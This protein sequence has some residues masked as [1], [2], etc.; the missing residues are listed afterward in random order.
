MASSDRSGLFHHDKPSKGMDTELK[1]EVVSGINRFMEVA[2]TPYTKDMK[3]DVKH[4]DF[5]DSDSE[6]VKWKDIKGSPCLAI[7]LADIYL[8]PGM[9]K[10]DQY[11]FDIFKKIF[12]SDEK[13]A[14][15]I[16]INLDK[17][18]PEYHLM[19]QSNKLDFTTFAEKLATKMIDLVGKKITEIESDNQSSPKPKQAAI[20]ILTE[21]NTSLKNMIKNM[22]HKHT[23]SQ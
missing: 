17:I 9:R 16:I 4:H 6:N 23:Q 18:I 1:G 20:R 5:I 22:D 10:H 3:E 15:S 19:G 14:Y 8:D 7:A 12:L 13:N 11:I 21:M 2:L